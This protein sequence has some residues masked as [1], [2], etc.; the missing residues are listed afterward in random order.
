M[1]K[2]IER[3]LDIYPQA[4]NALENLIE[5]KE[6]S[7]AIGYLKKL[8][9]VEILID[10]GILC[11]LLQPM[12]R[13]DLFFQT[14]GLNFNIAA[15]KYEEEKK[16]LLSMYS[17]IENCG[18]YFGSIRSEIEHAKTFQ[19]IEIELKESFSFEESFEKAKKLQNSIVLS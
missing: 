10:L 7:E 19:K 12:H 6:N 17:S 15:K 16:N 3:I 13:L 14:P 4:I 8:K 11:D 5:E 1:Y 2:S 9:S 18:F